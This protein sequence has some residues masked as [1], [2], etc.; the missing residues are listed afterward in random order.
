MLGLSPYK[1]RMCG[2]ARKSR[3]PRRV[4]TWRHIPCIRMSSLAQ[5]IAKNNKR[6]LPS[7]QQVPPLPTPSACAASVKSASQPSA[8]EPRRSKRQC[9]PSARQIES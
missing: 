3:D 8:P 9:R 6:S 4:L 5:P 2:E 7:L 1:C